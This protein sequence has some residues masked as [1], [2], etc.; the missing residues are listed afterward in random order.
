MA[1]VSPVLGGGPV[2]SLQAT[3]GGGSATEVETGEEVLIEGFGFPANADV[4]ITR[5]RCDGTPFGCGTVYRGRRQA[6]SRRP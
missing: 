5:L 2:C 4:E 3:V 1:L 6:S